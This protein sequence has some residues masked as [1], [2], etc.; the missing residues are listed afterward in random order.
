[1]TF[2]K[3]GIN[4]ATNFPLFQIWKLI[5]KYFNIFLDFFIIWD[6]HSPCGN[7]PELILFDK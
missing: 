4:S 1:M 5:K 6:K 3:R 2:V 7:M